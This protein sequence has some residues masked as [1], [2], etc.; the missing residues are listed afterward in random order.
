MQR[1]KVSITVSEFM[2]ITPYSALFKLV[3]RLSHRYCFC[4]R[5][6]PSFNQGD[7]PL[8]MLLNTFKKSVEFFQLSRARVCVCACGCI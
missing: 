8:H 4:G 5:G 3:K 1:L 7:I 6:T 2:K